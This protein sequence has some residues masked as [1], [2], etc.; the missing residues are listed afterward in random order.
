M[1]A[2][3]SSLIYSGRFVDTLGFGSSTVELSEVPAVQ[4][5]VISETPYI[6]LFQ[7]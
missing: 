7:P 1:A 6:A 4:D 3:P 2:A 5:F